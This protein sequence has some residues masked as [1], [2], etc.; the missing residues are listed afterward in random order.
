MTTIGEC[1]LGGGM[2][3]YTERALK[4]LLESAIAPYSSKKSAITGSR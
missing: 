2:T 1:G 3:G 4:D